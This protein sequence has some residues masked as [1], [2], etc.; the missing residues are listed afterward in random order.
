MPSSGNIEAVSDGRG[1]SISID[2]DATKGIV[3]II[4]EGNDI[5]ENMDNY[6]TYTLKLNFISVNDYSADEISVRYDGYNLVV[7]G[8]YDSKL[9]LYTVDGHKMLESSERVIPVSLDKGHIYIV[10]IAGKAFKIVAE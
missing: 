4:V 2:T 6:H 10:R 5:A 9:E 8:D 1:A 3:T 7:N